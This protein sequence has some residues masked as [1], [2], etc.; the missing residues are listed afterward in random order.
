MAFF[1]DRLFGLTFKAK[2]GK[3]V[4]GVIFTTGDF[5]QRVKQ[6]HQRGE[7]EDEGGECWSFHSLLNECIDLLQHS[8]TTKEGG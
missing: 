8:S 4:C 1:A 5:S 7:E 6:D 2:Q 3:T